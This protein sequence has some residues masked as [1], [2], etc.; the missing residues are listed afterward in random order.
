MEL[1]EER[2]PNG[3][4]AIEEIIS[5]AELEEISARYKVTAGFDPSILNQRES[6]SVKR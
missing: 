2:A 1:V 3:F 5:V 6:L 4:T